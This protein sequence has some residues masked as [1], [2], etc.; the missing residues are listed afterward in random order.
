MLR[1]AYQVLAFGA[2]ATAAQTAV[3]QVVQQYPSKPVRI[4]VPLAPGGGSD[5]VGRIVA[6]A[7]GDHWGKP[8]VVDNRP[9]AGS[10]VGTSLASKAAPDGYTLLVSSPSLAISPALYNNLDFDVK[11][12]FA[13]V[14]L[15]A[16]QPSLLVVHSSVPATSLKELIALAARQPGKLAYEI[17]G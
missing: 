15:L 17:R 14:S 4:V 1:L 5:I 12:D 8:V 10:A 16:S 2:C 3:A 11:R 6:Q 9:G 13:P 7:L